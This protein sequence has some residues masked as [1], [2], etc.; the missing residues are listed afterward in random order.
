MKLVCA[1]VRVLAVV[2]DMRILVF[3]VVI[4]MRFLCQVLEKTERM[5]WLISF[6]HAA[7]CLFF[8]K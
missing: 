6:Y 3:A 2:V 5:E 1:T 8:S 4:G 7:V